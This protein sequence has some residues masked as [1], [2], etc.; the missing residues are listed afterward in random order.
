MKTIGKIIHRKDFPF[1][2]RDSNGNTQYY[3]NVRGYFII[4][5]FDQNGNET[6]NEDSTGGWWKYEYDSNGKE[7]YRENSRGLIR[8]N[9]P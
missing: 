3:E 5:K 6:Y 7:I 9:R 4:S 2:L 8:D 1:G